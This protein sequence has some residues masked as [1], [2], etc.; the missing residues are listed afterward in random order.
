MEKPRVGIYT[1]RFN[2]PMNTFIHRQIK[3][4]QSNYVPI[5]L[6]SNKSIVIGTTPDYKIFAK[7]KTI[8]GRLYRA[9]KKVTGSYSILSYSQI[10]F[11]KKIINENNIKFIHAHYGPSG[12]EIFPLAFKMKMPLLVSF[13]G[14][15]ASFLLRNEKYKRQIQNVFGYAHLIAVSNYMAQKLTN[16]GA[17]PDKLSVIYYGV[18]VENKFVTRKPVAEKFKNNEQ[19]NFLQIS[20]FEEKKG[21]IYTIRA[22]KHFLQYYSNC[23]L[24]FGGNGSLRQSAEKLTKELNLNEK[25]V[26]LGSVNPEEVFNIMVDADIFLHHSITAESGDEE[27]IPNVIMEAMATGLPVISTF[28]AGIPELIDDGI[29]G[30]LV[31]EKNIKQYI[32]RMISALNT[33]RKICQNAGNKIVDKFNL[34]KQNKKLMEL[35]ERMLT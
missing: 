8:S 32:N 13:H 1:Q 9:L 23:R 7:E 16:A 29:N 14:Y 17:N 35:Y 19:I 24:I 22:F 30:Y 15:D 3:G 31:E 18:T 11:F 4:V 34:E 12:L 26:F 5:I 27:G 2:F 25:V 21:H 20:S 6:T 10:N 28:H 33:N